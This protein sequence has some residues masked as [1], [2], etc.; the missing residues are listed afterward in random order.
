MGAGGGESFV[1]RSYRMH[2]MQVATCT[3][4]MCVSWALLPNYHY[5]YDQITVCVMS[6]ASYYKMS[7]IYKQAEGFVVAFMTNYGDIHLN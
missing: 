1:Q 3:K 7:T 4:L 6:C 2:N 5:F